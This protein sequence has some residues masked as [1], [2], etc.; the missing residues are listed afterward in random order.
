MSLTRDKDYLHKV[1]EWEWSTR[2][3]PLLSR[4]PATTATHYSIGSSPTCTPPLRAPSILPISPLDC[5]LIVINRYVDGIDSVDDLERYNPPPLLCLL[6][7]QRG[8]M[9]AD[10]RVCIAMVSICPSTGDVVW[11]E[12]DGKPH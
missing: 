8:G 4:K 7:E 5:F 11:D 1:S 12:F 2:S 10:E 9:G 3:K 6:E